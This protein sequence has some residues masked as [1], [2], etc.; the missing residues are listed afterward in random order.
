[1]SPPHINNELVATLAATVSVAQLAEHRT[2]FVGSR[3]RFPAGRPALH[4]RNRSRLG[5]KKSRIMGTRYFLH[6]FVNLYIHTY[7]HIYIYIYIYMYIIYILY[8]YIYI[9]LKDAFRKLCKSIC[10]SGKLFCKPSYS[11]NSSALTLIG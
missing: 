6:Q 9:E 7:I 11:I 8:I 10:R 5:L 1:M 2:R 3:V 4:F